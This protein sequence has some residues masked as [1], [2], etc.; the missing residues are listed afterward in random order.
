VVTKRILPALR[1]LV[2]RRVPR[3]V[4]AVDFL[5]RVRSGA[6]A[7]GFAAWTASV[8]Y[9]HRALA[10]FVR[11]LETPAAKKKFIDAWCRG[12]F[13]LFGIDL[14]LVEGAPPDGAPFLVVANHRSP[15]DILVCIS[16]VGGVVL[17]HDGVA[18]MPIFGAAAKA[19]D[20]I[21]VDREDSQSGARA[22]RA[23]RARMREGRNV[24]VFP[25]GTTFAGDE[26]R[27]FRRGA[28]S[29]AKGL[30]VEVLPIGLAYPPGCEFVSE[31]FNEHLA[32]MS[33]RK[34]TP[35]WAAIG[36]PCA[37]PR[38][39]ADEEELRRAVQTLVDRAAHARDREA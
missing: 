26:V 34:K 9:S 29:A 30:D 16:L 14:R 8:V 31:S 18:S 39:A 5:G 4:A 32:R 38:N 21:F 2:T 15:L 35:V 23:M 22:I 27:A 37:V 6:R 3:Y 24:I 11:D 17:S 7:L 1:A 36:A 25:E 10:T 13:P 20:T 28:F 33:A 19:T 12:I